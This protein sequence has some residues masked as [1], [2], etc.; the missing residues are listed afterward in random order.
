MPS[1]SPAGQSRNHGFRR[2]FPSPIIE[3]Q[4]L[5]LRSAALYRNISPDPGVPVGRAFLL[6]ADPWQKAE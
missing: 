3:G 6:E 2:I 1:D 4:E 5:V